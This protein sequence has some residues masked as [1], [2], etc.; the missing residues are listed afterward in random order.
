MNSAKRVV[1]G[2]ALLAM[3]SVMHSADAQKRRL[4]SRTDP[5]PDTETGGRT[6]STEPPNPNMMIYGPPVAPLGAPPTPPI[7]ESVLK[8]EQATPAAPVAAPA[9]PP[10]PV[11]AP[12]PIAVPPPAPV[13]APAPPRP[14]PVA[15]PAPTPAPEPPVAPAPPPVVRPTPLPPEPVAV[16]IPAQTPALPPVAVPAPAVVQ[17][18][19]APIAT[20]AP[21]VAPVITPVVAAPIVAPAAPIAKPAPVI[22]P[23]PPAPERREVAA[24]APSSQPPAPKLDAKTVEQIF[25][26]L[27][28]GLP[29]DWKRTWVVVTGSGNAVTAKF[30]ATT[31]LRRDDGEEYVPCNAQEITR[32]IVGLNSALPLEQRAWTSARLSIDSEGAYELKYDY[33]K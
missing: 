29:Q 5:I 25:S 3:F 13:A 32:R 12:A 31:S 22:A 21:V 19:P 2:L 10:R 20:P 23:P 7:P 17:P 18:P 26:C 24:V 11:V 14:E 6:G 30:Y 27:A 15:L 16:P 4:P 9:P 8:P 28:P 1:L 33:D